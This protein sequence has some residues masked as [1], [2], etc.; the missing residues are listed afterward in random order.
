[1]KNIEEKIK[2]NR[3]KVGKKFFIYAPAF[4]GR[5]RKDTG[6][7]ISKRLARIGPPYVANEHPDKREPFAWEYSVYYWWWEFLRR[8]EGYRDCCERGGKGRY[9]KLYADWGDIHAYT[10][11]TFWG[12]WSGKVEVDGGVVITR[13][14]YLF[15]EPPA[16]RITLAD[17]VVA[18]PMTL[19]VNL[20]LEVRTPELVSFLRLFLEEH[21]DDVRKARRMS[22]ALYP[23]AANV[24]NRTLWQVLKVWDIEQA[25]PKKT[26][27]QYEKA[28]MAGI[29]KETRHLET[30]EYRRALT[31]AEDYI[32]YAV[33]EGTFPKRRPKT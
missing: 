27:T 5:R 30:M 22:Q 6:E 16:R 18:H 25:Y 24:R 17:R 3:W 26:K 33:E 28:G 32:H 7:F 15:S 21:K 31:M 19:T 10:P 11:E 20:P 12:W 8:H 14:E 23:V 4:K 29:H 13:G 1:M 2:G 9:K